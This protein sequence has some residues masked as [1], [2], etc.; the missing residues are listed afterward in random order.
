MFGSEL[1]NKTGNKV[2]VEM[3]R[4]GLENGIRTRDNDNGECVWIQE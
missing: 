1:K 2:D 3:D 4:V